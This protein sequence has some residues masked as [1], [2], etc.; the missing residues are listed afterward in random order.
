MWDSSLCIFPHSELHTGL[1]TDLALHAPMHLNLNP[2]GWTVFMCTLVPRTLQESYPLPTSHPCP[3]GNSLPPAPD[4][5]CTT[6]EVQGLCVPMC[7]KKRGHPLAP[8]PCVTCGVGA[9]EAGPHF[10]LKALSLAL[11]PLCVLPVHVCVC[12]CE[13]IW[14][15]LTGARVGTIS[16]AL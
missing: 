16:M 15:V 11:H 7:L 1:H 10:Q 5:V 8:G 12:K 13:A 6:T 4:S 3:L 2:G 14:A 9:V